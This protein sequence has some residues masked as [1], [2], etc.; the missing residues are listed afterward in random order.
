MAMPCSDQMAMPCS[1]KRRT[2]WDLLRTGF[3]ATCRSSARWRHVP[4]RNRWPGSVSTRVLEPSRLDLVGAVL[5][6]DAMFRS[7]TNGWD[8]LALGFWNLVVW[9][10]SDQCIALSDGD[11]MFRSETNGWDQLA[12][13]FWNLVVWVL[14]DQCIAL[15]DGYAMLRQETNDL[16]SLAYRFPSYSSEQC[17]MAMPCSDQKQMVGIRYSI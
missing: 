17:S 2:T 1:D 16:G 10:L 11:A 3:R 6:G 8:Q 14:S 15:S 7:E 12:L 4:I 5:D 9:V 13:G